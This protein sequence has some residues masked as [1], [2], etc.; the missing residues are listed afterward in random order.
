M[1]PKRMNWSEN[2]KENLAQAWVAASEDPV[3][4]PNFW[5]KVGNVFHD[6][7]GCRSRSLDEICSKFRDIRVK[8]LEFNEIYNFVINNVDEG[9][10][11]A[12]TMHQ[13]EDMKH[14]LFKHVK[15]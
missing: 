15:A 11:F 2:E 4:P 7:M 5:V 14:T 1:T 12:V 9:D 8:C 6:L 3:T 10:L 13:Y